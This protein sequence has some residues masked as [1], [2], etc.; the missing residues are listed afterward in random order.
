MS[1][2]DDRPIESPPEGASCAQH[3]EREAFVTCPRC[4]SYCCIAC[5]HNSMRRC[6]YCL[7][8]EPGPP[9]PWEDRA[10]GIASRFAGTVA[11]AFRPTLSAPKF[12]TS[13]VGS[14]IS[15]F[16]LTFVPVALASGIIPY[17]RTL[18]FGAGG[19]QLVG[20]PSTN[21]IAIDVARA[22]G[23]GL[24]VEAA[25]ILCL[26]VPYHSLSRAYAT[27]GHPPA[28][29]S[30]MLYRGWLVPLVPLLLGL[31]TWP[32]PV[33]A[34]ESAS[35]MIVSMGSLVPLL[36]LLSSMLATARMAS[37][38]GPIAALIVV[39]VPFVVMMVGIPL[40]MQAIEPWLPD[41]DAVRQA[42]GA[43]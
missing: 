29:L 36:V 2:D 17:T 14:A 28:A 33:D 41:V 43:S 15:F 35:L 39:L 40:G 6:H 26:A 11:D 3:P 24:L 23:L 30:A 38:V 34:G 19:V 22:A 7:L 37:G 13:S 10:R 20:N 4:G 5:W 25:K 9:V 32:L 12:A 27:R 8:R 18:L 31:L 42:V 21:E 1:D 16:A